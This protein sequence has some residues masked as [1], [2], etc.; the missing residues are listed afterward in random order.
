MIGGEIFGEGGR[1]VPA[2]PLHAELTEDARNAIAK[3]RQALQVDVLALDDRRLHPLGFDG[4][5]GGVADKSLVREPKS[6]RRTTR[7]ASM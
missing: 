5:R 1:S 7:A 3:P 6:F 4:Q 2:C